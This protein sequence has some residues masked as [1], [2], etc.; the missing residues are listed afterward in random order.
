MKKKLIIIPLLAVLAATIGARYTA[1]TAEAP[2]VAPRAAARPVSTTS[3]A[4]D[5]TRAEQAPETAPDA[6][7]DPV[8]TLKLEPG[9]TEFTATAYCACEKCCGEWALNRPDGIVYTASGAV[10][11]EGVTIAADW[12]VLPVGTV[13]YIDGLGERV[14]QDRGGAVKGNAVDLYFADHEEALNF[15]RQTVRLYIAGDGDGV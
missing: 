14:V 9:W 2:T 8:P 1:T 15:G 11:H 3:P 13:V 4:W 10:A 7:P 12:D 6:L 5:T